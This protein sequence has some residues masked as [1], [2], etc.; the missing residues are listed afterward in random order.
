MDAKLDGSHEGVGLDLLVRDQTILVDSPVADLP[1]SITVGTV[2]RVSSPLLILRPPIVEG[3]M[4]I[5]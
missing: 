3:A 4:L 2:L 1:I 5:L